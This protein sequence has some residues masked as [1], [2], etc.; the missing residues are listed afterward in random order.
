M[1]AAVSVSSTGKLKNHILSANFSTDFYRVMKLFKTLFSHQTV[2]K[3]SL[4]GNR[5]Q[6][7]DTSLTQSCDDNSQPCQVGRV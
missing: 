3:I 1:L 6:M 5:P 2:L 7:N 4:P